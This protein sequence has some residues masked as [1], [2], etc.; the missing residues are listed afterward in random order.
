MLNCNKVI[1]LKKN[2]IQKKISTFNVSKLL[3]FWLGNDFLPKKHIHL[4]SVRI[5]ITLTFCI[6]KKKIN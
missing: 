4:H 6:S 1:A 3:N 5:K 2:K